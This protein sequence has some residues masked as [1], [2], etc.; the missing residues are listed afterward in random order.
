MRRVNARR[1]DVKQQEI[2]QRFE[3]PGLQEELLELRVEIP[4]QSLVVGCENSE[5]VLSE[6]L[7]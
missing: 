6:C 4:V 3:I 2:L 7:F 1:H 5:I